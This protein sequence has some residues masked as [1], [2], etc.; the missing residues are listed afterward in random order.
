MNPNEAMDLNFSDTEYLGCDQSFPCI[1]FTSDGPLEYDLQFDNAGLTALQDFGSLAPEGSRIVFLPQRRSYSTSMSTIQLTVDRAT[2]ERLLTTLMIPPNVVELLH[3]NNGGSW[4]HVSQCSDNAEAHGEDAEHMGP[5]AYHICFKTSQFELMYARHDFHSKRSLVLIMGDKLEL[6]RQRLTSQFRDLAA[7]H[8][9]HILLAVLGTWLRKL[10]QSRW[11]LDFEVQQLEQST[12]SGRLLDEMQPL[13]PSQL[14]ELRNKTAG[15]QGWIR[16]VV[17][18]SFV[19]G[20]HF[21][22]LEDASP[23]FQLLQGHQDEVWQHQFAGALGQYQSQQ[24]FQ[25]GQARELSGRID[26]QW[27]VI[28]ESLAKHD[29]DLTISMAQK[30]R[31]DSLLMRQMTTISIIFLPAT[32]LATFFSMIFFHVDATGAL[33]MSKYIWIYFALTSAI[34]LAIVLALKISKTFDRE[35]ASGSCQG[36]G[37][38][39]GSVLRIDRDLEAARGGSSDG[40]TKDDLGDLEL[41]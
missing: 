9:F 34:S 5:C 37:G 17:R 20:E 15:T 10:E 8:L 31:S 1:D 3:E 28:A 6:E 11:S 38:R 22:V 2:W 24:K 35:A 18:H 26:M 14:S 13:E 41:G 16:S 40:G 30:A 27:S 23:K 12:G 19:A 25:A 32:F 29:N 36:K 39:R 33:S 4:Q 21:R 7:V